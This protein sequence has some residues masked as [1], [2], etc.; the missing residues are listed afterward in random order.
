MADAFPAEC[1]HV[2]EALGAVYKNDALARERNLSA[3]ERLRFH[4]TES[5]PLMEGLD[6]WLRQQLDERKVEPNSGLGE[7]IGYMRKHW[8]KLTLFLQQ[9]GAP[10]DNKHL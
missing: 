7:A 10:L 6:K 9:P 5:G 3:E 8:P 4:R 2:L 1:R